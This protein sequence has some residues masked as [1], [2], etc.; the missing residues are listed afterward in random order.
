MTQKIVKN[1]T[2]NPENFR[3]VWV[4]KMETNW[5]NCEGRDCGDIEI[6]ILCRVDGKRTSTVLCFQSLNIFIHFFLKP[7]LIKK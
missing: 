6:L 5:Q 3:R 4:A 2:V 1:V 7:D